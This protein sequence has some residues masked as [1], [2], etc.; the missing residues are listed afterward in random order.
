ML[1]GP[2]YSPKVASGCVAGT[3]K[4]NGRRYC[5][6]CFDERAESLGLSI[7]PNWE[8]AVS[9][10][11]RGIDVDASRPVVSAVNA[12]SR[13]RCSVCGAEFVFVCWNCARLAE[14][15]IGGV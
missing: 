4:F 3:I 1:D 11:G 7:N 13:Q 8:V 9:A 12:P 15:K 2:W 6:E 10:G 5:P 14:S